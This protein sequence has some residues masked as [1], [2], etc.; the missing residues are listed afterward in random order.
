MTSVTLVRQIRARPSIVFDLLSTAEGLTSWWGPADRPVLSSEADVRVGGRYRVRFRTDDGLEHECAG[1]FLAVD[2]P[3]SIVL[4]W[5]WTAG[6][7]AEEGDG[8]SRVEMHVR[9]IDTGTE[10]TLV[11][12]ELRNAASAASHEWGWSGALDK[13]QARLEGAE[14]AQKS[15]EG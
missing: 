11:L 6:G 13:L 4:S 1:E 8:V 15:N 3:V 7:E 10:L 2:P 14:R 5:R 12:A 9:P